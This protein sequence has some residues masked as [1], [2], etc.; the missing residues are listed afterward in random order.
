MNLSR[1]SHGNENATMIQKIFKGYM[2]RKRIKKTYEEFLSICKEI[3]GN[4][5]VIEKSGTKNNICTSVPHY[6]QMPFIFNPNLVNNDP[7][8]VQFPGKKKNL[9]KLPQKKSEDLKTSNF[10]PKIKPVFDIDEISDDLDSM[11]SSF[12][13]DVSQSSYSIQEEKK[14]KYKLRTNKLP[15]EDDIYHHYFAIPEVSDLFDPL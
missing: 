3:E 12:S 10:K 14:Q 1:A 7:Y 11:S 6:L 13:T 8:F 15:P 9:S 2:I 5:L 4:Q